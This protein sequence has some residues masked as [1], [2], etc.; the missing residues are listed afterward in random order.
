LVVAWESSLLFLLEE[1][2]PVGPPLILNSAKHRY[3]R[4][5]H[6]GEFEISEKIREWRSNLYDVHGDPLPDRSLAET[7]GA[8]MRNWMR[9]GD[10]AVGFH[11]SPAF[12][13][14][15]DPRKRHRSHGCYRMSKEESNRLFTWAPVGTPVH[16]VRSLAGTKW[17]FL[18]AHIPPELLPR[19]PKKKAPARKGA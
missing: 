16:V 4:D 11:Y 10:L 15:T 6:L 2:K 9:I 7:Q 17:A 14:F 18:R 8:V 19:Q 1:G 13:F 12:R 5:A 3:L